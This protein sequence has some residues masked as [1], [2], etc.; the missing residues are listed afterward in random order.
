MSE[1]QLPYLLS[2]ELTACG[3][4]LKYHWVFILTSFVAAAVGS[5]A[6]I[7][8][9]TGTNWWTDL[10]NGDPK[11]HELG[12]GHFDIVGYTFPFAYPYRLVK[13]TIPSQLTPWLCFVVH[14]VGQWWIISQARTAKLAGKL[15]W[16]EFPHWNKYALR[17]LKLNVL[18]IVVRYLQTHMFYDGL[19]A[20]F[21]SISALFS[22]VSSLVV[23][24][25]FK[26]RTRG[27]VF[28][29]TPTWFAGEVDEFCLF[30]K[31]YHGYISSFG[32]ILNFWH[33]PLE[34]T[35]AHF[36]GFFHTFLLLWQSSLLY[37]RGHSNRYWAF[38]LESMIWV[39][40]ATVAYC[41]HLFEGL[42]FKMFLCSFMLVVIM[43]PVWGLPA[44][45]EYVAKSR[46]RH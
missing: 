44:L 15:D 7:S 19:S 28:G 16:T 18:M 9:R 4:K 10:N 14:Q 30:L 46:Q 1:K 23:V 35:L 26:F 2:S 36:T 38:L 32:I 27:V 40:G 17:M 42:L 6:A 3:Y 37:Q 29:W 41:Q 43:G 21:P 31:H 22:G 34:V 24:Y 12:L 39:H 8:H 5:F 45:Q 20:T 25:I 13:S 11:A 33:H